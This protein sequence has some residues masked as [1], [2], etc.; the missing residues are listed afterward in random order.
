VA[1]GYTFGGTDVP[2]VLAERGITA[3]V[4]KYRTIRSGLGPMRMP[5]IH[6]KDIDL[7]MARARSG[8]PH[9]CRR[10]PVSPTPSKIARAPWRR[11]GSA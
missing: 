9:G 8:A 3:F 10:L 4:I 1:L 11:C 7:V 2:R 5:D 6:I